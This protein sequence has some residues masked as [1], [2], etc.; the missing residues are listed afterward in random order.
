MT[1][2]V[3]AMKRHANYVH[4]VPS[5]QSA[6]EIVPMYAVN[7]HLEHTMTNLVSFDNDDIDDHA[8]LYSS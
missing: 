7:A 6:V 3:K 4:L 5:A 1:R 8:K 2:L